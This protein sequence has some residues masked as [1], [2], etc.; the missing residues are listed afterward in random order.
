[1]W[2]ND[3]NQVSNFHKPTGEFVQENSQNFR[4]TES[5]DSVYKRVVDLIVTTEKTAPTEGPMHIFV[6]A[7]VCC[8]CHHLCCCHCCIAVVCVVAIVCCYCSRCRCR[9]LFVYVPLSQSYA[10][11]ML[12]IADIIDIAAIAIVSTIV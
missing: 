12:V 1:M 4:G 5:V 8:C 2:D 11:L 7:A 9:C 6:I 10:V 3:K